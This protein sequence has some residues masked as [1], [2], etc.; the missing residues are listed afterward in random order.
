MIREARQWVE[1]WNEDVNAWCYSNGKTG[2]TLFN[3][4]IT[5]YTRVTDADGPWLLLQSGRIVSDPANFDYDSES[6]DDN[7]A[8]L[9]PEEEEEQ[10]S[11]LL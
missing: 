1:M 5:G 3:P 2:E 6:F 4:P 7:N 8:K 9:C 10:R 11:S